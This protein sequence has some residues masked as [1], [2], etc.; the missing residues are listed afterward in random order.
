MKENMNWKCSRWCENS[1]IKDRIGVCN[2]TDKK[3]DRIQKQYV[4]TRTDKQKKS[5]TKDK[6]ENRKQKKRLKRKSKK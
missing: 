1:H 3:E 4:D 2:I 6:R 5:K